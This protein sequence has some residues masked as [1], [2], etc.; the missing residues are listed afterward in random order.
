MHRRFR[1]EKARCAATSR[2]AREDRPVTAYNV[3]ARPENRPCL[4]S[5]WV[6][7]CAPTLA[8]GAPT[9][10]AVSLV[11]PGRSSGAGRGSCSGV[12]VLVVQGRVHGGGASA[13]LQQIRKMCRT[14]GLDVHHARGRDP[15]PAGLLGALRV[16]L[17]V[18]VVSYRSDAP[19]RLSCGLV[20]PMGGIEA[21]VLPC[22]H[23]N[24]QALGGFRP[25][26][27]SAA[28]IRT[29]HHS[30]PPATPVRLGQ[31]GVQP[32]EAALAMRARAR[33]AFRAYLGC[34]CR[35]HAVLLAHGSPDAC[36]RIDLVDLD[37]HGH[38]M[39]PPVL[40]GTPTRARR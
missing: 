27:H 11:V 26:V 34:V 36:H 8:V 13:E 25:S 4:S 5:S 12:V 18:W 2:A 28:L 39:S 20:L 24:W 10:K 35:F 30:A 19:G 14:C 38:R 1:Q 17:A 21:R 7:R 16:A 40:A 33:R 3:N 6:T 22:P 9:R 15:V 31:E 37:G 29:R 23:L 32:V